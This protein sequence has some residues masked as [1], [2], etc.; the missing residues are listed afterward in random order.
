VHSFLEAQA[1]VITAE[2]T[3]T[4]SKMYFISL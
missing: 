4:A 3:K 1:V 2:T